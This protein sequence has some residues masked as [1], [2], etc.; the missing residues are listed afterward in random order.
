MFWVVAVV[1]DWK[2][3]IN[4]ANKILFR[5]IQLQSWQYWEIPIAIRMLFPHRRAVYSQHHFLIVGTGVLDC[6]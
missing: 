2:L 1:D 6:P 4:F 5:P 3:Q